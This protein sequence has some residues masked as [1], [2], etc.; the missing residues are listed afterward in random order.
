MISHKNLENL[1]F[2]EAIDITQ[3]LILKMKTN[4]LSAS[5][6]ESMIVALVKT[7]NGARGFFVTYLTVVDKIADHPSPEVIN[8]LKASP[9]IVSQLLV[10]NLAMSTATAILHRR[11]DDQEMAQGSDQVRH[12][13]THLIKQLPSDTLSNHLNQLKESLE[14]N[15]GEYTDFLK[16][17]KYD[18]EQK[19]AIYQSLLSLE[20]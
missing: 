4:E 8:A 1:S 20:V 11:N 3:S 17:W 5:E 13:T 18:T 9:E 12:R 19:E 7:E 6:I 16:R 14:Q 15:K 2:E 10:K